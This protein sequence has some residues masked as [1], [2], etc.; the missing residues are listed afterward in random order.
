MT[1]TSP[2]Q[3]MAG[4]TPPH[5]LDAE[6]ALLG[7]M[8]LTRDAIAEAAQR[9]TASDF[10][11]PA[12][13]RIFEAIVTLYMTQNGDMPDATTVSEELRKN[14]LLETSGGKQNLLR[15]QAM[16]PATTNASH[17]AHIVSD[18]AT[19]RRL[20]TTGQQ[21]T[22]LAYAP[23]TDVTETLN[24]AESLTQNVAQRRLTDTL[25][26]VHAV[27]EEAVERWGDICD[28]NTDHQT[29]KSGLYDLDDAIRLKRQALH[30]LA[31]RPG[32]GKTALA[33]A[34]AAN[35][36]IKQN[37]PVLFF[38]MEMSD[39][40]LAT[41]LVSANSKVHNTKMENGTLTYSD[42]EAITN[43]IELLSAAPLHLDDNPRSTVTE[44]TMK[45]RRLANQ[46][47]RLG[48]I[49]IDYLQLMNTPQSKENRQVEVAAL[50]RGLKVLA[51]ELDCP[52][53]ALSQLNRALEYRQNK[54]PMLA[55]LRESGAIEQDADVVMFI[56]RDDQ[57][58]DD[59]ERTNLAEIIIAKNRHGPTGKA[60]L[61]FRPEHATFDNYT[62]A[63][64][65]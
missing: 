26:P 6:E 64:S 43:S 10:Y 5:N 7:A 35:I 31:A 40:E 11:R 33:L 62:G 9:L 50:S 22:A 2:P 58:G 46:V 32:Q 3:P 65:S 57:Y 15:L 59:K 45:A 61:I 30:V 24:E 4:R 34:I 17:Y 27:L 60:N 29:P 38:S 25:K 23:T 20:I 53:L 1:L 39:R 55:D 54:R 49:V 44:M 37:Q 42:W 8:L 47:G 12:N 14:G 18:L 56:Y 13:G 52:V 19:L 36:A 63:A 48:L 16:T 28:G 51:R 21:I 41:R